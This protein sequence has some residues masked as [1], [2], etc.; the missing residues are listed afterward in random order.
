M[1]VFAKVTQPYAIT[2]VASY[3]DMAKTFGIYPLM[4]DDLTT[5]RLYQ[6]VDV[7]VAD[8]LVYTTE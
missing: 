1:R 5:S 3:I 2:S 4:I 8:E 6:A 7:K